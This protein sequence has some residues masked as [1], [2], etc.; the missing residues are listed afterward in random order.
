M[1]HSTIV[2]GLDAADP[3][4]IEKWM[5]EGKMPCLAKL[6]DRG[7][8]GRLRNFE[9]SNVETAWTTFA[10]GGRPEKTGHWAMFGLKKGSYEM[11]TRAAYKFREYPPFFM[12]CGDRRVAIFDIPQVPLQR[13]LNGVHVT[14]WVHIRRRFRRA[15]SRRNYL[16]SSI[17]RHGRSPSLHEDFATCLDLRTTDRSARADA[18]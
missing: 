17:G 2:I 3:S 15:P 11:E 5:Q 16:T 8:Y 7:C 14:A 1:N 9:H 13:E 4:L 10:T 18:H 6:K 12:C